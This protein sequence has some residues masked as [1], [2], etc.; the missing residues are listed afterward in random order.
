MCGGDAPASR[1]HTPIATSYAVSGLG[2][3]I[4]PARATG[5]SSGPGATRLFLVAP[6]LSKPSEGSGHRVEF[7][8]KKD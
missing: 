7:K 1:A 4:A 8:L 5:V 6:R 2:A 3:P